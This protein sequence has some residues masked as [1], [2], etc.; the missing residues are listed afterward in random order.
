MSNE[1][2]PWKDVVW[3][4]VP[5]SALPGDKNADTKLPNGANYGF[6]VSTMHIVANKA[7]P[8]KSGGSQT[9][10]HYAVASGRY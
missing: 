1:L 6:P 3:L 7:R 4:Q 8:R 10:C 9:V 2:K 5:F